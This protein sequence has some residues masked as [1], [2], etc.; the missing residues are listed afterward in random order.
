MHKL[1]SSQIKFID[2]VWRIWKILLQNCCKTSCHSHRPIGPTVQ[3]FLPQLFIFQV[4][5]HHLSLQRV[6]RFEDEGGVCFLKSCRFS[7]PFG[8]LDEDKPSSTAPFRP[9]AGSEG[10]STFGEEKRRIQHTYLESNMTLFL[11]LS[12]F[13]KKSL[14]FSLLNNRVLCV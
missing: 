4:A 6:N 9:L 2:C 10:I 1:I 8:R 7:A 13:R 12:L 3:N 5:I 11:S 14:T